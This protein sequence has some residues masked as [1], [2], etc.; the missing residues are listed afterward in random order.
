MAEITRLS[1]TKDYAAEAKAREAL[2]AWYDT[3]ITSWSSIGVPDS[4]IDGMRKQRK[5]ISDMA[6]FNRLQ[7]EV[8]EYN[9]RK[10]YERS[11]ECY[12]RMITHLDTMGWHTLIPKVKSLMSSNYNSMGMPY[13]QA[14]QFDEA[15]P[16]F[17]KA[18]EL[19]TPTTKGYR[20]AARWMGNLYDLK[21]GAIM[22]TQ[23]GASLALA[24]FRK[25]EEYYKLDGRMRNILKMRAKQAECLRKQ[26]Q[27]SE[28]E[29]LYTQIIEQASNTD[30]LET[31]L[32]DALTGLAEIE[33][34]QEKFHLAAEHFEQGYMLLIKSN[35]YAFAPAQSLYRLY[36]FH[37]PEPAKATLWEQRAKVQRGS[38]EKTKTPSRHKWAL[39][40][41]EYVNAFGRITE[42]MQI[43]N[44]GDVL[45]GIIQLT[46]II[47][48]CENAKNF[49]IPILATCY[50]FRAS[51]YIHEEDYTKA[52]RDNEKCIDLL[53]RTRTEGAEDLAP[54]WYQLAAIYYKQD[55]RQDAMRAA[56]SCVA[57]SM[58][59]Y[60]QWHTETED[61]YSMRA[62][63]AATYGD[64][65][66]ALDDLHRCFDII[67]HNI[68]VNFAYLT[69]DER[70]S[71][72]EKHR[73]HSTDMF[74]FAQR[75]NEVQGTFT[76][77]LY[78][79]QL[80]AKGLM[81]STESALQRIIDR[82]STLGVLYNRIASLRK[83]IFLEN[84][85]DNE[86]VRL[87]AE[88]DQMERQMVTMAG[89]LSSFLDFMKVRWSDVKGRLKADEAAVEFVDY[90]I[91][92]DSTMYAALVI[93]PKWQHVKFI[94][95]IEQRELP[96]VKSISGEKIWRKVFDAIGGDVRRVYFAAS[97]LLY[98]LP[99]ENMELSDGRMAHEEK[100]L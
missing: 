61:A 65:M 63:L 25:A 58:R 53:Y 18:L 94:P 40:A 81:L 38:F 5:Q 20:S 92:K 9:N 13:L 52:A 15:K 79:Q 24:W 89:T 44:H 55:K 67:R 51:G 7:D 43:I 8:S 84:L 14:G 3:T 6:V 73:K 34:L 75:L 60:G 4:I 41:E 19:E 87:S 70:F 22:H 28:A 69:A 45:Q 76:N 93:V 74:A 68:G 62:N 95:L 35:K 46:N 36:T 83:K 77:D 85:D 32:G 37:I 90:R 26:G 10:D 54:S 59:Y 11:N 80:L 49:P 12:E 1:K 31:I 98:Q 57:V 91:G 50:R 27:T 56:D 47:E 86:S 66:L 99:I 96:A 71:Y 42:A 16:Y 78:D 48:E 30:S 23:E 29:K 88:A 64:T 21:A 39:D 97:G 17:E 2:V 33:L 82:D 100:Q 72:W